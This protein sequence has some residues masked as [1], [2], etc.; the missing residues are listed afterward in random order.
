M[1]AV[2]RIASAVFYFS[3]SGVYDTHQLFQVLTWYV[4]LASCALCSA[5]FCFFGCFLRSS[6]FFPSWWCWPH[7]FIIP[8]HYHCVY[9]LVGWFETYS[10]SG[11][12]GEGWIYLVSLYGTY[13]ARRG[14]FYVFLWGGHDGDI[15]VMMRERWWWRV[16]VLWWMFRSLTWFRSTRSAVFIARYVVACTSVSARQSCRYHRRCITPV[17]TVR[18]NEWQRSCRKV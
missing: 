16:V 15:K 2:L 4:V 7:P 12:I 13:S 18:G 10:T 6:F 14:V 9:P 5:L 11:W 17:S 8:V 3:I 1:H